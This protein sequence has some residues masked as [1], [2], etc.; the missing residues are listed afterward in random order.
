[1]RNRSFG[2]RCATAALI[3]AAFALAAPASAAADDGAS[4]SFE[5][6]SVQSGVMQL[7][8]TVSPGSAACEVGFGGISDCDWYAYVDVENAPGGN[9]QLY[10]PSD[11]SGDLGSQT[12]GDPQ[13]AQEP[14]I[15]QVASGQCML[16]LRYVDISG[17]ND[18]LAQQPYTFPS[19]AAIF[20][21]VTGTASGTGPFL[22]TASAT[23]SEPI[24]PSDGAC[25]WFGFVVAE[26]ASTGCPASID[27]G[28]G[29]A[30]VWVGAVLDGP[31]AENAD[32]SQ[33]WNTAA[34]PLV[35][36]GYI[37]GPG[38]PEAGAGLFGQA[39][40]TPPASQP[41]PSSPAPTATPQPKYTMTLANIRT[42]ALSAVLDQ[43]YGGRGSTKL[44]A[45]RTTGCKKLGSGRF[46]CIV[47]W[48]KKPYTFAGTVTTG[49][50]NVNTG[51]FEFGFSL[52]R[53]NLKTG[54][55]K[56]INV[57]Y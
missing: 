50:V 23:L 16:T 8:I 5:I 57:A 51:H 19:P 14:L 52:T 38:A 49:H 17:A 43:F 40:Y 18:V 41:P 9:C 6:L 42:W 20:T 25:S 11:P 24:C 30:P 36:C 37:D 56:H 27:P 12:N 54:A 29:P 21:D 53:R 7:S 28:S 44:T 22:A 31:G 34:G 55:R 47:S 39:T 2:A 33:V 4:G 15:T 3:L 1:M 48:R 13:T 32:L 35:W 10:A 46:R 26:P 45:F